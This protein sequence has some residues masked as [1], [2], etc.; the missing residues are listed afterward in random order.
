[1]KA[2]VIQPKDIFEIFGYKEG[3]NPTTGCDDS[4]VDASR[5]LS[6][7]F[8]MLLYLKE[9]DVI[10]TSSAKFKKIGDDLLVIE[11]KLSLKVLASDLEQRRIIRFPS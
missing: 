6:W 2:T 7:A 4:K 8:T 5:I 9:G 10:E 1:M 11:P 3:V